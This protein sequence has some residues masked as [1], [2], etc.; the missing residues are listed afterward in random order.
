M[1]EAPEESPRCEERRERSESYFWKRRE[2]EKDSPAAALVPDPDAAAPVTL[3][4][5]AAP[6]AEA[7]PEATPEETGATAAVTMA[8]SPLEGEVW[9]TQLE[10]AGME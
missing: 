10:E 4:V 8:A 9:V 6:E 1:A 7:A 3:E 2:G 5:M